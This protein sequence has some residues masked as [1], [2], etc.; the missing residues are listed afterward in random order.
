MPG[1][2]TSHRRVENI[3]LE[4]E[5]V[6]G[7][8]RVY[9]WSGNQSQEGRKYIPDVGNNHLREESIYLEWEPI[10]ERKRVYTWS[11]N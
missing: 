11:G 6:T 9:T 5:P 4:W 7:G 10:T 3:Y 2:E 1:V 8:K